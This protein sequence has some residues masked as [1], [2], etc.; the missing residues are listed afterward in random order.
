MVAPPNTCVL[1][2]SKVTSSTPP[3]GEL[4]DGMIAE[5]GF[6]VPTVSVVDVVPL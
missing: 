3:L 1:F 6:P 2:A 4:V 5:I